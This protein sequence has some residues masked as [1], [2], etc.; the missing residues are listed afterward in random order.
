MARPTVES[1]DL[2]YAVT[3]ER[4]RADYF[5]HTGQS[6]QADECTRLADLYQLRL[7]NIL[8]NQIK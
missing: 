4:L 2:P 3:W 5:A 7:N 6:E 1:S 8:Q